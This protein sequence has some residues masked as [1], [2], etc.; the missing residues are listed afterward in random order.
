M[1]T[2]LLRLAGTLQSWGDDSKFEIR[3]T[4]KEPTKSGVIGLLAA[5]LGRR[6]DESLDDLIQLKFGVRVDKEGEL[7]RDYHTARKPDGKTC[8]THRYYLSDATFLVGLESEDEKQLEELQYALN[9]PVYALFLGR[10]S[11]V[12]SVPLVLG[13][14]SCGLEQAL[15]DEPWQLSEWMQKREQKR[16]QKRGVYSLRLIT[17]ADSEEGAFGKKDLPISFHPGRRKYTYRAVKEHLPV[18]TDSSSLLKETDHD[19]MAEL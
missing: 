4:E 11:C 9:H 19:V 15:R 18:P 10:R 17:D 1:S 12:P 7:L 5:A 14:R 3:R 16:E 6:R 2:L 8:V 13:I